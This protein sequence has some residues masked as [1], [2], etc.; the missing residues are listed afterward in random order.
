MERATM[1]MGAGAPLDLTCPDGIIWP[2]TANITDEVRKPYDMFLT[3]GIQTNLVER[4]YQYLIS[5]FPADHNIWWVA[6]PKPNIHFE[7][8]FHVLEQ[9]RAY[10]WVWS[11]QCHNPFRYPYFAPFTKSNFDFSQEEIFA[12][13]ENFIMRIMDIVNGYNEYYRNNMANED[14]FSDFFKTDFMWDVFNFNYDTMVEDSLSHYEDGYEDIA[15]EAFQKFSPMKLYQNTG[16]LSTINHLHGC[17]RYYY[18]KNSNSD[19]CD[20]TIHDLYKYPDYKTV[21]SMMMGRGQSKDV[22]QAN[23]EY[24][25]GP[26]ITGLKK[27]D[28]LSCSPYDC[29]HGNLYKA[30][31]SSNALV[32]VGYSFGDIYVNNLIR[33]MNTLYGDKKRIVIIDKWNQGIIDSESDGLRKYLMASVSQHELTFWLMM[34][35]CTSIYELM[36]GFLQNDVTKVMVSPNGCLMILADG[37]KS[38]V[39]HKAEIDAFLKS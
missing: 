36:D 11:E 14:W 22:S 1:I 27:T 32:I 28:K 26:I 31:Y 16:Q 13:M 3:P 15:G 24:F 20:T 6:N 12:V 25:A 34:T 35:G 2:S 33:M 29:Y 39:S 8:L 21:K 7:I 10:E 23:E 9:M 17:I 30:L 38:A 37:F 4:I 5:V 18:K 19:L